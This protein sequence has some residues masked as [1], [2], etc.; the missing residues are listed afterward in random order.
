MF[1]KKCSICE[2][3]RRKK[4]GEEITT[5]SPTET[6]VGITVAAPILEDLTYGNLDGDEEGAG[7]DEGAGEEEG[8]GV[9]HDHD[10]QEEEGA[11]ITTA[12]PQD[13][14]CV[15]DTSP[16]DHICTRN[17]DGS[18]GATESDGLMM[19]QK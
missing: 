18:S 16:M 2:S 19:I 17:Y 12:A 8:V 5:A 9:P 10:I 7:E 4:K 1:S 13:S 15:I 11:G 14:S 6:G 3:R